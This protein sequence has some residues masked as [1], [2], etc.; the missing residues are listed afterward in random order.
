MAPHNQ[1][2]DVSEAIGAE[3]SNKTIQSNGV[4]EEISNGQPKGGVVNGNASGHVESTPKD[5]GLYKTGFIS[6]AMVLLMYYYGNQIVASSMPLDPRQNE[7]V[8][9]KSPVPILVISVAY[10]LFVTWLGPLYMRDR[11]PMKWL[12]NIMVVFNLAQ[13]IFYVYIFYLYIIGGW[14]GTYSLICQEC[15]YSNKREAMIMLYACYWYF[16]SKLTD[17]FDT[18]FFV[19]NKKYEHISVLH[20]VHHA[21]MPINTYFVIRYYP[22]GH[23]TFMAMLNSLV[24]IVMYTYY[25]ISAMGPQ[26]RKFLWWKKYLTKMQITQF[27]LVIIHEVQMAF[28]GCAV[29]SP[30]PIWIGGSTSMFLL[31]F[32]DFYIKAYLNKRKQK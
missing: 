1:K 28:N 4:S 11:E 3:L 21:I 29:P 7:W 20:A 8:M 19:L 2:S 30:I 5:H 24:H 18:V 9:M 22:G 32:L 15:D 12:K 14:N 27:C 16:I 25:G 26:Y 23:S 10:V 31:L 13:V 17:L 6:M